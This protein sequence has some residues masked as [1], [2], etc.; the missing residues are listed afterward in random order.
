MPGGKLHSEAAGTGECY[1]IKGGVWDSPT[2]G[3]I[4]E[5][6]GQQHTHIR[7]VLETNLDDNG[8]P[9]DDGHGVEGHPQTKL[10]GNTA[11][12][13]RMRDSNKGG[14]RREQCPRGGGVPD[15][16]MDSWSA[17]GEQ[18]TATS[19]VCNSTSTL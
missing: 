12:T 11:H 10:H 4:D 17:Q 7:P 15:P 5:L 19:R 6:N 13:Y 2:Q 3:C 1:S 16:T 14:A 9:N 8:H 18:G